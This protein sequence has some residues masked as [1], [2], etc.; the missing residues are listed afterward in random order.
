MQNY[1]RSTVYFKLDSKKHI[2]HK[3]TSVALFFFLLLKQYHTDEIHK[4]FTSRRSAFNHNSLQNKMKSNC[5]IHKF[6]RI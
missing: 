2:K 4:L 6:F 3:R 1:V 5:P